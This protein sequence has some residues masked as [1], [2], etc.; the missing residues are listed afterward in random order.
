MRVLLIAAALAVSYLGLAA[1][2]LAG[3]R[4]RG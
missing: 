1:R 4:S 2:Y 3:T